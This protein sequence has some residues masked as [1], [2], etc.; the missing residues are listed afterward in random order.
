MD[1]HS[2]SSG[3]SSSSKVYVDFNFVVKALVFDKPP[4]MM[5]KVPYFRMTWR[6]GSQHGGGT[7]WKMVAK[8]VDKNGASKYMVDW[9][10]S[11]FFPTLHVRR[12]GGAADKKAR[13]L[14]L[15]L[16]RSYTPGEEEEEEDEGGKEDQALKLIYWPIEYSD[17]DEGKK[18][19]GRLPVSVDGHPSAYLVTSYT[20]TLSDPNEVARAREERKSRRG[21]QLDETSKV[22][23]LN[24]SLASAS[25]V[26]TSDVPRS[27]N[28]STVNAFTG[29][30]STHTPLH[31]SFQLPSPPPS[32]A[33]PAKDRE[34][35]RQ[36]ILQVHSQLSANATAVQAK[37]SDV[38]EL[39][40]RYNRLIR[41]YESVSNDLRLQEE[42][43]DRLQVAMEKERA[44]QKDVEELQEDLKRLR[45]GRDHDGCR[46]CNTCSV[47]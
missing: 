12:K 37:K 22:S 43:F 6:Y 21:S 40:E 18:K 36:R 19:T 5:G 4:P 2:P 10:K 45:S 20:M 17:A 47:Q 8:G 41:D 7:E 30:P 32:S 35:L 26:S 29:S 33:L 24:A 3:A 25:F 23:L 42:K 16:F 44:A 39:R 11:D 28:G 13:L 34:T 9:N 31:T 38:E 15:M 46:S 27:L 14:K 1:F